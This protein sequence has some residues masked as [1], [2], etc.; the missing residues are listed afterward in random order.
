MSLVPPSIAQLA[1]VS[2]MNMGCGHFPDTMDHSLGGQISQ[3]DK[4]G[5]LVLAQAGSAFTEDRRGEALRGACL[6]AGQDQ[7]AE[8]GFTLSG[9]LAPVPG[10]G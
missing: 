9:D 1:G 10:L 5:V 6:G 3:S 4:P 8:A 2:D 7:E